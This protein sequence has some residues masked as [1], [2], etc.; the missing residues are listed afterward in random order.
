MTEPIPEP[1]RLALSIDEATLSEIQD[2]LAVSTRSDVGI[3]GEH[4]R[5]LLPPQPGNA[6][7]ELF[8]ASD[9]AAAD[10]RARFETT[11]TS[12]GDPRPTWIDDAHLRLSHVIVPITAGKCR[13]GTVVMG[14]RP[15]QP[16]D[17]D[18]VE[19]L[20]ARWG[21][22]PAA[23]A[24]AAGRC[25]PWTEHERRT[26][27]ELGAVTASML[28]RLCQQEQQLQDRMEELSAVYDVAGMLTGMRNLQEILNQTAR[29]VCEVMQMK[30][31]SIRL[32]DRRTDEL[33]IKAVHNLSDAYLRKGPV[34]AANHPVDVLKGKMV[35]I[36]DVPNDPRVKYPE[37]ARREGLVSCLVCGMVHHGQPVGVIRVYTGAPHR[38]SRFER[39]LLRAIADQA[40][41]AIINA[42]LYEAAVEAERT[43]RQLKYAGDVQ[44]RMIPAA[45]P[46]WPGA[47]FGCLYMPSR[48]VGGDF[49]DF[50]ELPGRNLGIAVADVIGKGVPAALMMASLRSALRVYTYHIYDVE[51]IIAQVNEHMCREMKSNEFA[52]VFY[53]VLMPG[54]RR[55]T[56][57]NAGHEPPL[58]LRDGQIQTLETG[59]MAVGVA[60]GQAFEK[61]VVEL[62]PGDVLLMCTDGV[63]ESMNFAEEEFGRQRLRESFQRHAHLDPN[64]IAK[65]ILWDVRRFIGFSDLADDMT[66]VIVKVNGS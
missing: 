48:E 51:R 18:H 8:A 15:A 60:R 63:V 33:V 4:G 47:S 9:A 45:P 24:D 17:A 7:G 41:V 52:T 32:Y 42:R 54:A 38:F 43:D 23:L 2:G 26:A 16:W 31:C 53:G 37:E 44:R 5:L 46:N 19:R 49:Y 66:M 6:L 59:G 36:E 35:Y 12:L 14:D 3:V 11:A 62:R 25:G 10:Q 61:G 29:K 40:A 50:I 27:M 20:A 58:L 13:L 57:C 65:N 56:Y 1:C 28:A 39:M 55:L 21:L 64:Q 22:N 30:G 34:I